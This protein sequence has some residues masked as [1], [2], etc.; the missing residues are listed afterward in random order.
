VFKIKKS[1]EEQQAFKVAQ[2]SILG[3]VAY[4]IKYR[5]PEIVLLASIFI[6]GYVVASNIKYSKTSGL[7]WIPSISTK[8]EIK[9][10]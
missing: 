2:N 7:E 5:G 9:K 6:G 10:P 3:L 8:V 4:C 1:D